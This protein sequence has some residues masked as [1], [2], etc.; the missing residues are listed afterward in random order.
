MKNNPLVKF[1]SS[2]NAQAFH[3]QQLSIEKEELLVKSLSIDRLRE[4]LNKHVRQD[5]CVSTGK[6]VAITER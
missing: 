5:C 1:G 4:K 6:S 3:W 2:R